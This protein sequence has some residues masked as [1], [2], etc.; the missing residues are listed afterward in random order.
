MFLEKVSKELT[1]VNFEW[2]KSIK[3]LQLIDL[4]LLEWRCKMVFTILQWKDSVWINKLID[5]NSIPS[6]VVIKNNLAKASTLIHS[7]HIVAWLLSTILTE[8][9]FEIIRQ[10]SWTFD[11]SK[12]KNVFNWKVPYSDFIFIQEKN[13]AV[14]NLWS[15]VWKS[16]IN[17]SWVWFKAF[18]N[19]NWDDIIDMCSWI[20]DD[21]IQKALNWMLDDLN[22]EQYKNIYTNKRLWIIE[23]IK[24]YID[25]TKIPK[26]ITY[27]NK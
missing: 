7:K 12:I 22:K 24:Y 11:F 20:M 8:L 14:N 16:W 25:K 4:D 23:L 26:I 1:Q 19:Y 6:L 18:M 27:L 9:S 10:Y 21:E 3:E 5:W 2:R 13:W 15:I 17:Y